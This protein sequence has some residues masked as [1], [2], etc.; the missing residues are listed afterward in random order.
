MERK[1][2]EYVMFDWLVKHMLR[3]KSN[4]TILEGFLSVLIGEQMRIVELLESESNQENIFTK[5]NRVDI[6]A[7]NHKQETVIIEVQTIRELDYM[8]RMLFGAATA[9]TEQTSLGRKYGNIRKVYTISIVYFGLGIGDDYLYHGQTVLRGVHTGD[10]L[11]FR[12]KEE[13]EG[14]VTHTTE[15]IFPEYYLI[16]VKKFKYQP[17]EPLPLEQWMNYLKTGRIRN[18]DTAQGLPEAREKLIYDAMSKAEKKAYR[19]HVDSVRVEQ[20]AIDDSREEGREEGRREGL[21]MVAKSLIASGMQLEEI[22][23]HT[24]LTLKELQKIQLEK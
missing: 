14:L 2:K 23:K 6:K 9:I 11:K 22:V 3:D 15:D 4:Y 13:A 24:G 10:V 5:F 1:D 17:E 21:V 20:D 16:R 8:E 12:R 18:D 19:D 7:R